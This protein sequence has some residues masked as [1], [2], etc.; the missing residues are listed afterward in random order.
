M[1][2]DVILLPMEPSFFIYFVFGV[3]FVFSAFLVDTSGKMV[4]R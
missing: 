3:L 2:I 4:P 1:N